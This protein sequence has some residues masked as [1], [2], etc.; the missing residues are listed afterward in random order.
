V[1]QSDWSAGQVLKALEDN[2][3]SENT[4][5]IFTSDNGP[6]GQMQVR[7]TRTGHNSAYGGVM[8]YD[9][10]SDFSVI[11]SINQVSSAHK[12]EWLIKKLVEGFIS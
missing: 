10:N 2:G 6:A 4:V 9:L 12:T 8:F 3:F 1:V 11:F 5:V 7:Y